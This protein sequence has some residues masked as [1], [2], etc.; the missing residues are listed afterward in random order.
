[1]QDIT[2]ELLIKAS[3]GNIA[4]FE[5]IYKAT[6]SFVYS[7]A[8]R[9]TRNSQDAEEVT[10]DV[11]MK[12]YKNLKSFEF[13]SAFRTW[14]YRIA[15]NCAIT[16]YRVTAKERRRRVNYENLEEVAIE[17]RLSTEG[18][19]EHDTEAKLAALL[20]VL[21]PQ[22]R[23]CLILRELEG[24]SYKGI[25]DILRIPINTVRSRL[26][27]AREALLKQSQ[28]GDKNEM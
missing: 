24:L 25:A 27:R 15:V 16:R 23:V 5:E 4:A 2:D 12:L 10:Q 28:G 8:W 1:M 21:N 20:S 22:Q 18:L 17:K 11:F 14:V 7:I 9:I 26:K 3:S 19:D 13:R 6:S